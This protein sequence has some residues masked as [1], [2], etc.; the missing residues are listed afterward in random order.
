MEANW[1]AR[2]EMH[3]PEKIALVVQAFC[4][5]QSTEARIGDHLINP[6]NPVTL[7]AEFG[8]LEFWPTCVGV[9]I[10]K[11]PQASHFKLQAMNIRWENESLPWSE[12]LMER[13][14]R[15]KISSTEHPV[16]KYLPRKGMELGKREGQWRALSWGAA[17][18]FGVL[19]ISV[20][21]PLAYLMFR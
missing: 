20:F 6:R 11:D 14:V 9:F 4:E 17:L 12:I 13:F 2:I 8:K 19:F 7:T 21:G 1:P 16:E 10:P 5:D 3:N 15:G 18:A